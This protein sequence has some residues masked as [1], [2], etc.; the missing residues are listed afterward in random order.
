MTT[1]EISAIQSELGLSDGKIAIALCVTRQT[2][3][4][5]RKGGKCPEFSQNALRWMMELRRLDPS[6]DNLPAAV[7]ATA[8]E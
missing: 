4:N 5:W 1:D 3:R 8:N 7:R 2:F 6:N